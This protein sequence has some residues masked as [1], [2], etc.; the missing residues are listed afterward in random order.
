MPAGVQGTAT[1]ETAKIEAGQLARVVDREIQA[2]KGPNW[3]RLAMA[4]AIYREIEAKGGWPVLRAGKRLELGDTGLRVA[5]VR[6]RIVADGLLEPKSLSGDQA[7][8]FDKG[9]VY[10]S[11][12]FMLCSL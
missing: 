4:L 1:S 2:I 11:Y 12:V 5:A 7:Q 10:K 9:S 6:A 8:I 3:I